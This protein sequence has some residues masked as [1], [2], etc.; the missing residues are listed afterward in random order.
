MNVVLGL[1]VCLNHNSIKW[2]ISIFNTIRLPTRSTLCD[3]LSPMA[4]VKSG[5]AH[6]RAC[7]SPHR[8]LAMGS[9]VATW[10][11]KDVETGDFSVAHWSDLSLIDDLLLENLWIFLVIFPISIVSLLY[12]RLLATVCQLESQDFEWPSIIE[13]KQGQGQ[14]PPRRRPQIA[15]CWFKTSSSRIYSNDDTFY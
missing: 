6:P 15:R 12:R 14:G 13:K 5:E 1:N 4:P 11:K 8:P 3:W 9:M 7:R 2:T 10:G